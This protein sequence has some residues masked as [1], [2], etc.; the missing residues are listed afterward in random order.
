VSHAKPHMLA[1]QPGC[2]LATMVVHPASHP[3]QFCG[4][5]VVS[6]QLLPQRVPFTPE[7]PLAQ[8]APIELLAHTAMLPEQVTPQAPQLPCCARLSL[9]PVPPS[10]Q[11]AKPGAVL[12]TRVGPAA[13]VREIA[14]DERAASQGCRECQRTRDASKAKI[15]AQHP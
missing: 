3:P 9:Q 11:L 8:P 7:Q 2:A 15:G 10:A 4:S 14:E 5:V 6:T 12:P 13:P 1:M